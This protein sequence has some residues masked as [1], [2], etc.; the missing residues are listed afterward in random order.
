[1]KQLFGITNIVL[2]AVGIYLVA[3]NNHLAVLAWAMPAGASIP[4]MLDFAK[5]E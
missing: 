2:W 4:F 1:M 3:S 5:G